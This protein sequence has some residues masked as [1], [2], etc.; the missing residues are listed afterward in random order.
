ML[1]DT[2]LGEDVEDEELG[3][4]WGVDR[5]RGWDEDC[6]LGEAVHNDQ[7]GCRAGQLRELLNEV[8]GNGVPRALG[9]GK[10]SENSERLMSDQLSPLACCA[11]SDVILDE[12]GKTWPM[13][14]ALDQ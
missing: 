11:A 12:R 3:Q 4:L 9:D 5:V 6:L 2:V 8:H 14:M 7:D 13:V 10:L 1:R